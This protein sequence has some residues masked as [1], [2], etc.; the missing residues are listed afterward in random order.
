MHTPKLI[1]M[2]RYYKILMILLLAFPNLQTSCS[3]DSGTSNSS[4]GKVSGAG[5]SL[6]RFAIVGNFLYIVSHSDL[7][8]YDITEPAKPLFKRT[9]MVGFDVETIFPYNDKLFIGGQSGMYIYSITEPDKPVREGSVTHFRACDP[10]VTN[11]TLSYV[12]LRNGTRCG[13]TRNALHVYDVK[14]LSTPVLKTE[15]LMKSPGGLGIK[16]NALYVCQGEYGM[17]VF[18]LTDPIK[19]KQVM[20]FK[21]EIFN[22]VIPYG[23]VLIAYIDKGVAFYDIANPV[24]PVLISKLKG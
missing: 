14:N 4:G 24:A 6:A 23:N 10:V 3:K 15:I 11:D 19:P 8:V 20:E 5:G 16:Q 21:D 7:D 2:N 9:A 18:N 17:V 1:D 13:G 22:D 12:T